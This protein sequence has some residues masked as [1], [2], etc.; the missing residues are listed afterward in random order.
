MHYYTKIIQRSALLLLALAMF[1]CSAP[2]QVTDSNRKAPEA[3][4]F[5]FWLGEW[6]LTWGDS[7]S[8]TN[9]VTAILDSVV[10][11]E[12]FDGRPSIP[13]VG[14]SYSVYVA[15]EGKWKQTWVDNDGGLPGFF[16]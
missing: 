10:T 4:Q 6:E 15:R 12:F 9:T 8:G 1:A 5:D 11:A 7:G 13:L 3:S 14:K 2:E 16:G